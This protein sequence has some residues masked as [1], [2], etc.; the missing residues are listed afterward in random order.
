MSKRVVFTITADFNDDASIRDILDI[1]G[2]AGVQV[3]DNE[4]YREGDAFNGDYIPVENV[5]ERTI[6]DGQSYSW[7]VA[8]DKYIAHPAPVSLTFTPSQVALLKHILGAWDLV[9]EDPEGSDPLAVANDIEALL[10]QV[11]GS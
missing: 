9:G 8:S 10:A 4:V 3:H 7:D 1:A 5:T 11:N 6:I 2:T